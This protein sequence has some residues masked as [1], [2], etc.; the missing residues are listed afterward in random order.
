MADGG[1]IGGLYFSDVVYSIKKER[2]L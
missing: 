1:N 2:I